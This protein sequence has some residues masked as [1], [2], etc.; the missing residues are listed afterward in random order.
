MCSPVQMHYLIDFF[1]TYATIT[2]DTASLMKLRFTPV[3]CHHISTYSFLICTAT[4]ALFGSTAEAISEGHTTSTSGYELICPSRTLA[5]AADKDEK[6]A[7]SLSKKLAAIAQGGDI[8]A[9]DKNGQT[10]LMY[11]AA[12]ND[13]LVTCWLVAKGA[14]VTL[15]SK[16]GKK[17][18]NFT[19]NKY[20]KSLLEVCENEKKPLTEQETAELQDR[21]MREGNLRLGIFNESF[22]GESY[23]V[24]YISK[25]IRAHT[26]LSGTVEGRL[27]SQQELSPESFAYLI[28]SGYDLNAKDDTGNTAL[29][30]N[31]GALLGRLMLSLGMQTDTDNKEQSFFSALY[32]DD[33]A[34]VERLLAETPDL[35]NCRPEHCPLICCA[36]TTEVAKALL[37]AGYDAKA[38]R[39]E[40]GTKYSLLYDVIQSNPSPGVIQALLDA[41]SPILSTE[42]GT[43]L[44]ELIRHCPDAVQV[45]EILIKHGVDI[46]ETNKNSWEGEPGPGSTALHYA[47]QKCALP[48]VKLLLANG[49]DAKKANELGFTPLHFVFEFN[50]NDIPKDMPTVV[51]LL[52]QAGAD[53]LAKAV[54][55]WSSNGRG[56]HRLNDASPLHTALL[57]LASYG[58]KHWSWDPQW[59]HERKLKV[60][61]LRSLIAQMPRVPKDILLHVGKSSSLTPTQWGDIA[62]LLLD[63]GADPSATEP[64][65][66]TTTLMTAGACDARVAARLIAA[67]VPVNT[68]DKDNKSA[69][70]FAK[71]K[72]VVKTL[73][74]AGARVNDISVAS[75]YPDVAKALIQAGATVPKD[76]LPRLFSWYDS[77][78]SVIAPAQVSELLSLF[79][80]AGADPNA[81]DEVYHL[82]SLHWVW[83]LLTSDRLKLEDAKA[84]I[85]ILLNEGADPKNKNGDNKSFFDLV[86]DSF[87]SSSTSTRSTAK[88]ILDYLT[89]LGFTPFESIEE[90]KKRF[91]E[92]SDLST[93][94]IQAALDAGLDANMRDGSG[95]TPLMRTSK[96]EGMKLLLAAGADVNA[97]DGDG[98]TTLLLLTI[99]C[100][101]AKAAELLLDAGADATRQNKWNSSP[102]MLA[103]KHKR[104]KIQKILEKRGVKE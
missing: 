91:A 93:A 59:A 89:E 36:S 92:G 63:K 79:I 66:G 15:T 104:A 29:N 65:K 35:L 88:A 47:A 45:A 17:A 99:A 27:L 53:P 68:H 25:A 100:D 39:Q 41:G 98:S 23:A 26:D 46:H 34:A 97:A 75:G 64:D 31:S 62:L 69:I 103:K 73:L 33:A 43:M 32:G 54:L 7:A 16:C 76:A 96:I 10:A 1:M 20:V 90:I 40:D 84:Y 14:D 49:A 37:A 21:Y 94:L 95:K 12:V 48:M 83:R 87:D 4:M 9:V 44:H 18:V 52:L 77:N 101:N 38:T 13:R 80:Q 82:A 57:L 70:E 86:L 28:R 50:G 85:K 60:E 3:L 61:G 102:L 67:G 74:K 8:N 30:K 6:R 51:S 5:G 19:N 72:R 24:E 55:S 42:Y 78:N 11:A 58:Y 71:N 56:L 22:L 81:K 2:R